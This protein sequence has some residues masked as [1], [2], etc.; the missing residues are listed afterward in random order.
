MQPNQQNTRLC[1]GCDKPNIDGM[2]E[3]CRDNLCALAEALS[4]EGITLSKCDEE[5]TR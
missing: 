4:A 1:L 5:A 2:C 3:T